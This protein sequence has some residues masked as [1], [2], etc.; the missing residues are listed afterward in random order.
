MLSLKLNANSAIVLI[1]ILAKSVTEC[2]NYPIAHPLYILISL[3]LI[4]TGLSVSK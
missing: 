4:V 1:L 3:I 2:H